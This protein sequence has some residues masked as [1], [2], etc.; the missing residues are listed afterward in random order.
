MHLSRYRL[1]AA[2]K[3]ANLS[4]PQ[5]AATAGVNLSALRQFEQGRNQGL[6]VETVYKIARALDVP[7]ESLFAEEA[8][9]AATGGEA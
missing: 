8:A 9:V 6:K 4:Q 1:V 3:A 7:M 2:R 5:L